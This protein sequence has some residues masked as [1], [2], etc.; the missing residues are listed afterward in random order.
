MR[1]EQYLQKLP[2]WM[3][4]HARNWIGDPPEEDIDDILTLAY[5]RYEDHPDRHPCG[6]RFCWCETV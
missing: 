4:D 3:R 2:E 1:I 5:H 6:Q